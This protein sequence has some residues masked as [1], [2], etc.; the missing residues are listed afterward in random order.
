MFPSEVSVNHPTFYHLLLSTLVCYVVY[1]A[2]WQLTTGARRRRIIKIHCCQPVKDNSELNS[3][4]DSLFGWTQLPINNKAR[5]ERKLLE[6]SRG[7]FLRHGNTF[8]FKIAFTDI[9]F[10]AEPENVKAMLATDFKNWHLPDRRKASFSALFGKG[11]FTSDGAAWQHSRDLLRPNFARA[12]IA[13]LDSFE[14]HIRHLIEAIPRDGSTVDIQE[15]FFRL[16]IDSATEFLFG[17]STN[18]LA[19]GASTKNAKEFANAFNRSQEVAGDASRNIPLLTNLLPKPG[20]KRD[21]KYVHDFVDHYVQLGLRRQRNR[22]IEKSASK[23]GER[24]VF[25]HELVQVIHDPIR[26]R[27]ELLNI[28]LAGRDS[29]ASLLGNVWFMLARRPDVWAK[30]RQEVDDLNGKRPTFEQIKNMRYLRYI[31]NETLRL[32][33]IVPANARMSVADTFLPRGGGPDGKSPLFIAK[34][35]TVAWSLYTMQRRR[36]LYGDDADEFKPERWETLRPGWEYLPF[37]GGPRICIGQQ[38]ALTEASYTT[39]R[40]MQEFRH[41][42]SRDAEPWTEYLTVTCAGQAAKISLTPA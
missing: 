9:Y 22:D 12:Q 8:H 4:K 24:Y 5:N 23:G 41:I 20:V 21:I 16:T 13:D 35:R 37:N 3:W 34:G 11:I 36:D 30:L 1:Y 27:S 7:R 10:T 32:Y 28:L 14:R 18:C 15:L 42:E 39:I 40:L 19:P 31:L 6:Y 2:Y 29:T 17:E 25:L 26:L 33:P 38:F